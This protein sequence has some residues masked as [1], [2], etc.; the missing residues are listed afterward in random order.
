MK[1]PH[2]F[3]RFDLVLALLFLTGSAAQENSGFRFAPLNDNSLGLWEGDRPVLVYNHGTITNAAAP[4]AQGHSGYIHPLYGLDGEVMTG[5]FPADHVYHRGLYWAWP[6]IRIDGKEYDLWSL[7]GIR[8]GFE[9]WLKQEANADIAVLEVENAWIVGEKKVM[10]EQVR[11]RI[12]RATTNSRS[13]D[14]ELA[15]TPTDQPITLWGAPGKSYGGLTLRFGKRSKTIITVPTG[16]APEDLLMAK[17]P[18]GDLS[19][20]LS[21]NQVSGAAIFVSPEHPDFP[22]EWMTRDYG[23]L[24][25]GWPGV[26]EQTIEPGRTITCR[27]RVWV[28]GDNP[29]AAEIQKAYDAFRAEER[30]QTLR[31]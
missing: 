24:A 21:Q 22:P 6:H 15:W 1:R 19:G 20:D 14:L 26:K 7:R 3:P 2:R 4:K 12:H 27:Y 23:V 28:H 13:I 30:K 11:L 10:R 8:I 25:V 9:R 18:W 16:R 29:E 17:L 31:P 5:D